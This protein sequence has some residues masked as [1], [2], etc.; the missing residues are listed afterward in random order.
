MRVLMLA[1]PGRNISIYEIAAKSDQ[2]FLMS[3][4]PEMYRDDFLHVVCGPLIAMF[5]KKMIS[6]DRW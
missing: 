6:L 1:N 3:A 5:S 2:A 4:I